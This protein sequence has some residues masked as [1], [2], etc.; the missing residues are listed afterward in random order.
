MVVAV[1]ANGK[2]LTCV[3]LHKALLVQTSQTASL[4]LVGLVGH[5]VCHMPVSR[6]TPTTPAMLELYTELYRRLVA[7][8]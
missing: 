2:N 3:I 5:V 6:K 4:C 8:A 1:L 7:H